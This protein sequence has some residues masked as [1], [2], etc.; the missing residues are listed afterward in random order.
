MNNSASGLCC[1]KCG[2]TSFESLV[3]HGSYILRCGSCHA[4]GPVTSWIAIGPKW[5]DTVKVFRDG[6]HTNQPVLA[7]VGTD[8]WREIS[9]LA[10][11]GTTLILR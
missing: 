8:I 4:L 7:G 9:R 6:D 3:Q 11:D 2:G 10:A 1:E 5:T